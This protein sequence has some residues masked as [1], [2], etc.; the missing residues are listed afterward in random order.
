MASL[1]ALPPPPPDKHI[2]Q[3]GAKKSVSLHQKSSLAENG[4]QMGHFLHRK[5]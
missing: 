3:S 4:A 5:P 1:R 2:S